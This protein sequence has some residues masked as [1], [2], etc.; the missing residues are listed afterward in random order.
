V[1]KI[2]FSLNYPHFVLFLLLKYEQKETCM[3]NI[4]PKDLD[5]NFHASSI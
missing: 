1:K 5:I 2:L 3:S 4:S